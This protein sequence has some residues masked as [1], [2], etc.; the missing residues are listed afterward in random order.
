MT[1][2]AHGFPVTAYS[3]NTGDHENMVYLERSAH[4][5]PFVP[6]D[7]SFFLL[8]AGRRTFSVSVATG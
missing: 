5:W 6:E 8:E 1:V 7:F 2:G 4:K 3:V